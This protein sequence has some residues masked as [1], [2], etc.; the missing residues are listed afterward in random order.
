MAEELKLPTNGTKADIYEAILPQISALTLFETNRT[1][2][3]ANVV[4]VLR[5][6]FGFFWV[7][8]YLVGDD[9]Q[10]VL[11]VFQGSVACSRIGFGRGVCGT[12]AK[13]AKSIVVDDV[14]KFE[15]HIACSSAS[16]SEIVVPIIKDGKVIG[17]L[18]VDSDSIA[19]FDTTDMNYL[20]ALC[21][22][23]AYNCF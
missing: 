11:N 21:Q 1:A 23:V 13:K 14:S 22:T 9:N 12:A 4:A 3:L 19:D 2:S 5:E 6:A 10:L 7:G 20:E 18:D 17:V 8:F 16:K 15:G